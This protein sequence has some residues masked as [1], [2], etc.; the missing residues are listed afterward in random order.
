M[1]SYFLYLI[2]FLLFSLLFIIPTIWSYNPSILLNTK[3]ENISD[4]KIEN[5]KEPSLFICTHDLF[6]NYD[7]IIMLTEILK[8]KRKFNI[9]S[10]ISKDWY[11]EF[12]KS[13]PIFAK[14]NLLRVGEKKENIVN[15]SKNIINEKKEN[16]LMFLTSN[17][18][19][20]GIYYIL[21]DL[22][23]PIIFVKIHNKDIENKKYNNNVEFGR[24]FKIEYKRI[25]NYEIEEDP[26]KFMEFIKNELYN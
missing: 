16:I 26:E 25:E 5:I 17:S 10:G 2:L 23:I 15:K 6:P 4:L 21:K 24:E 1:K 12:F 20:K 19:K 13:L 22:K 9:V 7:Q 18:K 11:N 14:Y 3:Y 8:N